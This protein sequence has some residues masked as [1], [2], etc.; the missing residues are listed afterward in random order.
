MSD[1]AMDEWKQENVSTEEVY[2]GKNVLTDLFCFFFAL[3]TVQR[4]QAHVAEHN[5]DE[6]GNEEEDS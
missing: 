6:E 3:V 2:A 5:D 4:K 1:A